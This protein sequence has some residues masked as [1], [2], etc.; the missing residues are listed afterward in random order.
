MVVA[1]VR[2]VV[3]L[4]AAVTF[5]RTLPAPG[6]A[7]AGSLGRP[8]GRGAVYGGGYGGDHGCRGVP[9]TVSRPTLEFRTLDGRTVSFEERQA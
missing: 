3:A 1:D 5:G 2:F 9:M 4:T 6:A 7:T 8:H